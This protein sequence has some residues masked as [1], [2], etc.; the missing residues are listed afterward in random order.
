MSSSTLLKSGVQSILFVPPSLKN[1]KIHFEVKGDKLAHLRARVEE[2]LE[3]NQAKRHG[4]FIT[5]S[6]KNEKYAPGFTYI[7]FQSRGFVNATGLSSYHQ[8]SECVSIFCGI[9]HIS[10]KNLKPTLRVDNITAS[11]KFGADI[12]LRKIVIL[13]QRGPHTAIYNV[14]H[15]PGLKFRVDKLGTVILFSS[16]KYTI[17]G[18]KCIQDATVILKPLSAAIL[19]SLTMERDLKFATGAD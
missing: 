12:D 2:L 1:L 4:N 11:G 14:N 7:I 17:V 19:T 6:K 9:F 3:F 13:L 16:G 18:L 10:R 8:L 15:Y 5:L